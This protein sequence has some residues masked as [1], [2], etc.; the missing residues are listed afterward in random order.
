MTLGF[1]AGHRM[2]S[3]GN[4]THL[5]GILRDGRRVFWRRPEL[6]DEFSIT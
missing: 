3:A 2:H 5:N 6:K 1:R 4:S